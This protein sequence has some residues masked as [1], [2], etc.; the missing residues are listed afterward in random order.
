MSGIKIGKILVNLARNSVTVDG[1]DA[2]LTDCEYR[3]IRTLAENVGEIVTRDEIFAAVWSDF[4]PWPEQKI[5]DVLVCRIRKKLATID[6]YHCIETERGIGYGMFPP[7][8]LGTQ[9]NMAK[10]FHHQMMRELDGAT[11]QGKS[12]PPRV[13]H[14]MRQALREAN[15]RGKAIASPKELAKATL[16]ELARLQSE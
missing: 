7:H 16:D 6:A 11:Y 8:K 4:G 10:T 1:I 14:A 2:E 9:H 3:L 12:I 15:M 5:L 13:H